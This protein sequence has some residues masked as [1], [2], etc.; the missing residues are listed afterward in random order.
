MCIQ[1]LEV[2]AVIE[3]KVSD[4]EAGGVAETHRSSSTAGSRPN[5]TQ[6]LQLGRQVLLAFGRWRFQIT[7]TAFVQPEPQ[8]R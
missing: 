4:L 8:R 3:R 5:W 2:P 7:L 1:L 6:P